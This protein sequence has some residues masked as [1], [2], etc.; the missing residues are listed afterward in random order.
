MG[1]KVVALGRGAEI[2]NDALA[3][4]AHVYV[5]CN[6]ESAASKLQDMGGAVGIISTITQG[7]AVDAVAG[8][9]AP[10]GTTHGGS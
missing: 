7:D 9:L 1:F 6:A 4:G 5:D 2:E 10:E 8:G 3:L